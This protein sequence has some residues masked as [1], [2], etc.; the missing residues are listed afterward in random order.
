VNAA[1]KGRTTVTARRVAVV[2]DI[3]GTL[4]HV[5]TVKGVST[6]SPGMDADAS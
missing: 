6:Y 3:I 1:F 5:P 2:M 4:G